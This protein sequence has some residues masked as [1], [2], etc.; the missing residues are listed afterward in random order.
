MGD[1]EVDDNGYNARPGEKCVEIERY[2]PVKVDIRGSVEEGCC[3]G[4]KF[5][6]ALLR[7]RVN[8]FELWRER[9]KVFALR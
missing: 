2:I 4:S 5:T 8:R 1:W 3:L 7:S 9:A 6:S